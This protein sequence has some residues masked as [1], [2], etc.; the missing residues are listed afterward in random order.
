M[1]GDVS[2]DDATESK[3]SEGPNINIRCSN[4]SKFSIQIGL[5]ST[6]RL[7]KD[8]I[9]QKCEIPAEQQRLIY[10]GRIL[11]DDQTL[12]SYGNFVNRS[13]FCYYR[14]EFDLCMSFWLGFV[15]GF[16]SKN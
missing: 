10:K 4:G 9:A 15:Y 12:Q 14:I 2:A 1:G 6:V 7:F 16:S 13:R 8:M 5:D 11:K 3:G